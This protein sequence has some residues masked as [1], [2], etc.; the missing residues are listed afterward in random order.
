MRNSTSRPIRP[1]RAFVAYERWT[2][3]R[4]KI[5]E[6]RAASMRVH[7]AA[8]VG[9]N[10]PRRPRGVG[11]LFSHDYA[12]Y[13]MREHNGSAW[14]PRVTLLSRSAKR[15]DTM[16]RLGASSSSMSGPFPRLRFDPT[17]SR[18]R[19]SKYLLEIYIPIVVSLSEKKRERARRRDALHYAEIIVARFIG[20]IG[21]ESENPKFVL[22]IVSWP[23]F[24]PAPSRAPLLIGLTRAHVRDV[25]YRQVRWMSPVCSL[26]FLVLG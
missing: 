6:S 21:S 26:T 22:G 10:D 16:C 7:N 17:S 15:P 18:S 12:V 8:R 13:T 5:F 14:R 11:G 25:V 2:S 24:R 19:M 20:R 3:R 23:L 1:V 9:Q 4:L